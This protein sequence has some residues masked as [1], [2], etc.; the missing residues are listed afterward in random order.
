M[1][2]KRACTMLRK[3]KSN[4]NPPTIF[5][6]SEGED[7]AGSP[8]GPLELVSRTVKKLTVIDQYLDKEDLRF[9]LNYACVY[10]TVMSWCQL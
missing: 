2:W 10:N 5:A 3:S 8:A 4:L 6:P 7:I 9:V 1:R